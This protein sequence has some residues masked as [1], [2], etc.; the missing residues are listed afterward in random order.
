MLEGKDS[1]DIKTN[2]LLKKLNPNDMAKML[3][4]KDS[5]DTNFD[6]QLKEINFPDKPPK[7]SDGFDIHSPTNINYLK[8]KILVICKKC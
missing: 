2:A 7:K 8:K 4:G 1:S 3:E 5:S 6:E